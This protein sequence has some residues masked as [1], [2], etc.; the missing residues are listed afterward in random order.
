MG[1]RSQRLSSVS[2]GDTHSSVG[3]RH[4]SRGRTV[5]DRDTNKVK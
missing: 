5:T 2:A 1:G 4:K 3:D